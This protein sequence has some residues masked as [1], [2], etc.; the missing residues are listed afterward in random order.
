MQEFIEL[1]RENKRMMAVKHAQKFFP[2]FEQEQLKEIKKCMALLA[3]PIGELK[4][5]SLCWVKSQEF[6]YF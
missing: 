5:K 3:F 4:V 1:I 6:R 2:S